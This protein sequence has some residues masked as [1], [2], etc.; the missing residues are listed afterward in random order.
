MVHTSVDSPHYHEWTDALHGRHLSRSVGSLPT[1]GWKVS[2]RSRDTKR[3]PSPREG[4]QGRPLATRFMTVP[5]H[6]AMVSPRL[7]GSEV[8]AWQTA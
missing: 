4:L 3:H 6:T 2:L 5:L 1:D 7:G 8:S